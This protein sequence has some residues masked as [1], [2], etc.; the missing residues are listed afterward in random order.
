MPTTSTTPTT[1]PFQQMIM[2]LERFWAE[3]GALIWQ[4]Y[5]E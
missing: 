1:S 4:P 3:R 2:R 5:S